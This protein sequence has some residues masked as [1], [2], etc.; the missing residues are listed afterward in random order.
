M[1]YASR[2][3]LAHVC[4]PAASGC[5]SCDTSSFIDFFHPKWC[6]LFQQ[7][8]S[9]EQARDT[10]EVGMFNYDFHQL[11]RHVITERQRRPQDSALFIPACPPS[12]LQQ[13]KKARFVLVRTISQDRVTNM[14]TVLIDIVPLRHLNGRPSQISTDPPIWTSCLFGHY[15]GLLATQ[16]A[17]A[18]HV[19]SQAPPTHDQLPGT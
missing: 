8:S 15:A 18:S 17:C 19:V 2:R 6:V 13:E 12:L 9:A 11:V 1:P 14:I 4:D 16:V 5:K 10:A 3:G 7:S